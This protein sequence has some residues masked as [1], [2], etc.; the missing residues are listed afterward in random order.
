MLFYSLEFLFLFLPIVLACFF[1]VE[2]RLGRKAAIIFL[3]V[4]S[5]A[6][7]GSWNPAFV[8]LLLASIVVN[9]FLG[10]YLQVHTSRYLLWGGILLNL[11]CLAYYKYTN[12]FLDAVDAAAG[13]NLQVAQIILPLGISFYT[14]QQ[15]A[16]LVDSYAQDV[17]TKKEG[18]WRYALFVTFFPHLVA[19][20]LVSHSEMMPQFSKDSNFRPRW[21]SLAVGLS[22]FIIGLTKKVILADEFATI[23]TPVFTNA[24]TG[25]VPMLSAWLGA[26]CYTFQVY[27]DFSGY[28]DMAIGLGRMFNIRLPMNFNSP[29]KAPSIVEF[30]KRWH[31]TMTRFFQTYVHMPMSVSLLRWQTRRKIKGNYAIHFSTFVTL[32]AIGLWHGANWTYIIFGAMQGFAILFTHLWR[33]L[34]KAKTVPALPKAGGIFLTYLFFSLSCVIYRAENLDVAWNMYLSMFAPEKFLPPDF[35]PEKILLWAVG[36]AICFFAPNTQQIMSNYQPVLDYK[37]VQ[38]IMARLRNWRW[39]PSTAWCVT[40]LVLFVANLNFLLDDNRVQEFIYFQF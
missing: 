14:F 8:P 23:S 26:L 35:R 19:G 25:T 28:S 3:V 10:R 24:A 37:N 12:F 34:V 36:A 30:W 1:Y 16:W 13:T 22:I 18:F 15:I 40:I 27:F 17:H 29:F 4:T 38:N 5:I 6:F 2:T 11:G 20:P 9:Y 7:Y 21:D 39:R 31:M 32:L 33:A